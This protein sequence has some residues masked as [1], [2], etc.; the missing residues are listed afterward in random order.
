MR[1]AI[2]GG[3]GFVGRHIASA[4]AAAGHEVVLIARGCDR[5]RPEVR[6]ATGMRFVAMGL[7][8]VDDLAQAFAGCDAVAHCAGINREL[9]AYTYRRVHIEGTRNVV[10]AARRAG[11]RR[12]ALISFLRARP[13]CGMAY[14][15]SKWAAEELVRASALDYTILKCGVI[16]GSGDH[17][18]DHL[19]RAFHTFPV[20]PFVGYSDKPIRPNAIEDVAR[21]ACAALV[22]GALSRRTVAVVGPDGLTLRGVLRQVAR[23]TGRRPWMFP[24][25]VWFHYVVG[26]CVERVMAVPL[27]SVAQVRMLDEGLAEPGTPCDPLPAE[28]APRIAFTDAQIRMGLPEPKGFGMRDLRCCRR[29]AGETSPIV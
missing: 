11:V 14:H 5:T 29:Q 20:F 21:I 3:T 1:I 22:D 4:L 15:E 17:M 19:S 16:Y 2:T 7:D 24:M 13:N 28:L 12:I 10:D 25:P 6:R 9:A 8:C 23:V 26:W 27:V 18:L